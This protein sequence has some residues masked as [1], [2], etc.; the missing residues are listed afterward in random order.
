MKYYL[1]AG[2]SSGDLHGSNLIK[3]LK[4]KDSEAEFR[5]WGGDRMALEA[6]E[7]VQHMRD[8]AFMGFIEVVQ[9]LSTIRQFFKKCKSDILYWKPDIVIFI[10]YPGFNLR[11][12]RW[13]KE[14]GYKTVFYISPQLWAWKKNRIKQIKKYVDLMVPILPFEVD[15][16]SQYG[17]K[18]KYEG[19]PLV[20]AIS[21]FYSE[22][23]Q[24]TIEKSKPIIALLPGSRV[25]E[26]KKILP[27]MIEAASHFRDEYELVLAAT[28]HIETSIY[29]E[30]LN[31]G[32]A[33]FIVKVVDKTYEVLSQA[34]FA[35][36]A[37]G[38]ATLET[39]LFDV[40]QIVCYRGSKI[41]FEIAKRIVDI[42][43]ISLVNL[44]LDQEVV[45]ELIQDD[46][47]TLNLRQTIAKKLK[48]THE[49]KTKYSKL[50]KLLGEP[51]VSD[52]IAADIVRFGM[53]R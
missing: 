21:D 18:V 24:K 32:N 44:I 12:A 43:Y 1:I 45:P 48:E 2:E 22:G 34:D 14:Q 3:A 11:M 42:K 16:Y 37:S 15:F 4:L 39:A 5:F 52:R 33:E 41:S 53:G 7:P 13:T 19:H 25:Q 38:T 40:P 36:V 28:S 17:I 9:N 8:M 47:N 23:V 20:D 49:T 27:T 50:H 35:L 29:E 31:R 10:D 46:F 6:G 26:I 51:R 30:I